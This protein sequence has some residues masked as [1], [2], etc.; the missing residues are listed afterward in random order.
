[1]L[2]EIELAHWKQG[3][4]VT[5]VNYSRQPPQQELLPPQE[6]PVGGICKAVAAS[7]FLQALSF[8]VQPFPRE[9][10][11]YYCSKYESGSEVWHP[12]SYAS[13]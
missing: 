4:S 7:E 5:G 6:K 10:I 3:S 11:V 1:M 2:H 8:R 12:D 9:T 13:L